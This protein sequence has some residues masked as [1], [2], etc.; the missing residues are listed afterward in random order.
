MRELGLQTF[1][2]T[3]E[4]E[5]RWLAPESESQ[6]ELQEGLDRMDKD[7]RPEW[8]PTWEVRPLL[9]KPRFSDPAASAAQKPSPDL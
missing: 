4:L 5:Q 9:T 2:C 1:E 7:W 6:A 3:F 8:F